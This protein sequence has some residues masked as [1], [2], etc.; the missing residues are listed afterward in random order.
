[1]SRAFSAQHFA[2]GSSM[3]P[4]ELLPT[5]RRTRL[6]RAG[7]F[8]GYR[9]HLIDL[10]LELTSDTA[11]GTFVLVPTVAAGEQFQRTLQERLGESTRRSWPTIGTRGGLYD[12][13]AF[14]LAERPRVL[15]DV[16]RE[17]MLAACAREAEEAGDPAP[18]Q[19]RPALVAEMIALYDHLR[20]LGRTV[21]DFDRLL[22]G[23]LEPAAESDRGAAQLLDQTRFLVAAFRGYEARLRDG[24]G[25][26]EQALRLELVTTPAPKPLKH[27]VVTVGD[28]LSDP[29]GLWPA[30]VALLTS[31]PGLENVDILSTDGVLAAG[32]LD[33]L[34]LAFVGIAEASSGERAAAPI[35]IVPPA[36]GYQQSLVFSYR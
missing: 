31:I 28:R 23:E 15:S 26:D 18:F 22:S 21:D 30:D 5:P 16:E 4:E 20:R 9:Q 32:Y 24:G 2:Q 3:L 29:E 7:D 11:A 36:V 27:A 1:M 14:R 33:R 8:A 13:L 25:D 35:L 10:A 12:D 6:L 19:L 17:A 34:R